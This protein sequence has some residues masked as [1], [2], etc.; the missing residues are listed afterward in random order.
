V[1]LCGASSFDAR[2]LVRLAYFHSIT[3]NCLHLV[4]HT[5]IAPLLPVQAVE[6]VVDSSRY[7]V[8]RVRARRPPGRTCWRVLG[9]AGPKR[10]V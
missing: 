4:V 8:V 2:K 1:K 3:C 7:F 6:Q 5:L 10:L 9:S